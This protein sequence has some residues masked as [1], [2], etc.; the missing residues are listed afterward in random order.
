MS[1]DPSTFAPMA[2]EPERAPD[3]VLDG[4]AAK[5]EETRRGIDALR[6]LADPKP[7]ESVPFDISEA[8]EVLA[9]I[10]ELRRVIG[11][12]VLAANHA[13]NCANGGVTND[14]C[15][16]GHDAAVALGKAAVAT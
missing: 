2:P 1:L 8:V 12:L 14:P 11:V 3:P 13:S 10:N 6:E 16:C 15:D 7:F 9:Y 4:I 5:A